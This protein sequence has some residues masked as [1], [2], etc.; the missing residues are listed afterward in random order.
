MLLK[1]RNYF[2]AMRITKIFIDRG[3]VVSL[4][5]INDVYYVKIENGYLKEK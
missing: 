2:N 4:Q 1:E 3:Y 5:I